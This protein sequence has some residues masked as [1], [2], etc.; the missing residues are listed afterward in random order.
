MVNKGQIIERKKQEIISDLTNDFWNKHQQ[1]SFLSSQKNTILLVEGK[2]DKEH[3]TN[4]YKKLQDEYP[5]LKFEIFKLNSETNILPFMRGLYESDF[6]SEKVYIGLFDNEKKIV[7]DF[8]N[9]KLYAKIENKEFRKILENQKPNNNYFVCVL[10]KP[11]N[12]D[13]ECTI[14][15]MFDSNKFEE[16]YS[17]AF[18]NAIGHFS[19]KSI[20]SI[21]E[22]IK[23]QAKNILSENSKNFVKE[24]FK[25]F[26]KLFDLILEI[27]NL[28]KITNNVSVK[29]ET[30][31]LTTEIPTPEN[32]SITDS[33][34][35]KNNST[36]I[37]AIDLKE[38]S[39]HKKY[40][41]KKTW[42][43]FLKLRDELLRLNPEIVFG[44][45]KYFISLYFQKQNFAVIRF[46][47][48]SINILVKFSE[49]IV[50]RYLPDRNIHQT[51]NG[52]SI[53]N[54]EENDEFTDVI[55]ML[56]EVSKIQKI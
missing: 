28:N 20:N 33:D 8:N 29:G 37:I 43:N 39:H 2:H 3:I 55:Y 12:I 7:A 22:N 25:H 15:T 30:N 41:S 54:I 56:Y 44:S 50:K 1:S 52:I 17:T 36:D 23:E 47:K 21:T 19:N 45:N 18:Q 31:P 46:R 40:T 49:F 35:G 32:I 24:D 51:K 11:D 5:N 16:A 4:A 10:P 9:P 6:A 14:E 13:C 26:R 53:E 42:A 27:S 38:Y 48:N 34:L